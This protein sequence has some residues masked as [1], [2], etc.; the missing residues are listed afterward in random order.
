MTVHS[1]HMSILESTVTDWGT[2]LS[3]TKPL[4]LAHLLDD[5]YSMS[6]LTSLPLDPSLRALKDSDR[7]LTQALLDIATKGL[8]EVSV[9]VL[10]D[11]A[12]SDDDE[13]PSNASVKKW[14]CRMYPPSTTPND[15]R[16]IPDLEASAMKT[17]GQPSQSTVTSPHDYPSTR[18]DPA[19]ALSMPPDRT[20]TSSTSQT[21]APAVERREGVNTDQDKGQ[22][23]QVAKKDIDSSEHVRPALVFWPPSHRTLIRYES[24]P[25]SVLL[26]DLLTSPSP[27][28]RADVEAILRV[29]CPPSLTA[30]PSAMPP[31]EQ[32]PDIFP[33]ILSVSDSDPIPLIERLLSSPWAPAHLF[34]TA[35][36]LYVLNQ[37]ISRLGWGPLSR[38]VSMFLAKAL[39]FRSSLIVHYVARLPAD[40]LKTVMSSILNVLSSAS[41]LVDSSAACALLD[42]ILEEDDL[43]LS[44]RVLA[45]PMVLSAI[46]TAS[47]GEGDRDRVP[48]P[49]VCDTISRASRVQALQSQAYACAIELIVH[50]PSEQVTRL[51]STL[52]G[53]DFDV[54]K[55]SNSR[56]LEHL[57]RALQCVKEESLVT[58]FLQRAI[59][60]MMKHQTKGLEGHVALLVPL[61][62]MVRWDSLRQD[63]QNLFSALPSEQI[64]DLFPTLMDLGKSGSPSAKEMVMYAARQTIGRMTKGT[65][66]TKKTLVAVLKSLGMLDSVDSLASIVHAA[67][68]VPDHIITDAL[69]ELH[70]VPEFQKASWFQV[71]L[72]Q[73]IDRLQ[74]RLARP[75]PERDVHGAMLPFPCMCENCSDVLRFAMDR[76]R[77]ELRI[78]AAQPIRSHIS[79]MIVRVQ[80]D[81]AS[82]THMSTRPFMLVL[83]KLPENVASMANL[84][85]IVAG[86][87]LLPDLQAMLLPR[88]VPSE[89]IKDSAPVLPPEQNSNSSMG[90]KKIK[91]ILI[92]I[93]PLR[94]P[95]ATERSQSPLSTGPPSDRYPPIRNAAPASDNYEHHLNTPS[96][97]LEHQYRYQPSR[98]LE[99]T[100]RSRSQSTG[101]DLDPMS[102]SYTFPLGQRRPY[103]LSQAPPPDDHPTRNQFPPF[104]HPETRPRSHHHD[105]PPFRGEG[106][107]DPYHHPYDPRVSA[108]ANAP[109]RY[110]ADQPSHIDRNDRHHPHASSYSPPYRS[111][112]QRAS[113]PPYSAN[114]TSSFSRSDPLPPLPDPSHSSSYAHRSYSSSR[115]SPPTGSDYMYPSLPSSMSRSNP[116]SPPRDHY[117]SQSRNMAPR[118][119]YLGA[120]NPK[121]PRYDSSKSDP[122]AGCSDFR[123]A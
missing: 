57:L 21:S 74:Q 13:G 83:R 35:Q 108:Y 1:H 114:A 78:S 81:L 109:H 85:S 40:R 61:L 42:R 89:D 54:E 6:T 80:L 2:S 98:P 105:L 90:S 48:W 18:S 102:P 31:T 30:S 58:P 73:C 46:G 28:T 67:T 69:F 20:I 26:S 117:G 101:R 51:M 66:T 88:S 123:V 77:M 76:S 37:A 22:S 53:H 8:L 103:P 15:T 104:F 56:T 19:S 106:G 107:N 55:D 97:P 95:S 29:M 99:A 38:P 93:S 32:M 10:K 16:T 12:D 63:M 91:D 44:T 79:A 14:V 34:P 122:E 111:Y 41:I 62:D 120:P 59:I 52:T 121:R 24:M 87:K 82:E 84:A 49:A 23:V 70:I 50:A 86:V 36:S 113:S 94:P 43:T 118:T 100:H 116:Y 3:P 25:F 47:G 71:M 9:A 5:E 45:L 75:F 33:F 27:C 72:S 68:S 110:S 60:P 115:P 119:E 96:P 65:P 11:M 4:L 64:A 92:H 39:P 112:H 17:S 7:R